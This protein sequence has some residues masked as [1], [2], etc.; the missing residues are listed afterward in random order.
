MVEILP[1]VPEPVV[2]HEVRATGE[3]SAA[4][5]RT[6]LVLDM[7]MKGMDLR[8]VV[9][10]VA[11]TKTSD[12]L[13]LLCVEANR[14]A[15]PRGEWLYPMHGA[16]AA[17]THA[18]LLPFIINNVSP[19]TGLST[20]EVRDVLTKW[21]AFEAASFKLAHYDMDALMGEPDVSR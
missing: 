21:C 15:V 14:E 1:G 11:D 18:V 2:C 17:E 9:A 4:V 3:V 10:L 7:F 6:D 5:E 20:N 12:A 13:A 16:L 8:N 19:R